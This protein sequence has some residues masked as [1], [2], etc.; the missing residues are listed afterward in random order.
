MKEAPVLH[1]PKLFEGWMLTG[2]YRSHGDGELTGDGLGGGY[3]TG[4]LRLKGDGTGDGYGNGKGSFND[5]RNDTMGGGAYSY[6]DGNG[7][8]K[9]S[10]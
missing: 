7:W 4:Q 1:W 5:G 2:E 9:R 8:S 10:M 3:I 6:S